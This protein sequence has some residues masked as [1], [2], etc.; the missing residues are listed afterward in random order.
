MAYDAALDK[1]IAKREMT[2]DGQVYEVTLKS[3]NGGEPKVSIDLKGGRFPLRRLTPTVLLAAAEAVRE[4]TA[5]IG[6]GQ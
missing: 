5:Q 3:Y 1:E 2:V 4:M 6:T